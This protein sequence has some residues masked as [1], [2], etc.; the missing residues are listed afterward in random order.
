MKCAPRVGELFEI[1]PETAIA[2]PVF[3]DRVHELC[4]STPA[5]LPRFTPRVVTAGP[6]FSEAPV[7]GLM[8]TK[9]L[10]A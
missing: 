8:A 4:I 2:K 7:V 6:T 5:Y 1:R 10:R 9:L 3:A